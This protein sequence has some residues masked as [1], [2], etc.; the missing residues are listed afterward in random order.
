[1][2]KPLCYVNRTSDFFY[3]VSN[4]SY[5]QRTWY[6]LVELPRSC[7]HLFIIWSVGWVSSWPVLA[8]PQ[9]QLSALTRLSIAKCLMLIKALDVLHILLSFLAPG[10]PQCGKCSTACQHIAAVAI[11]SFLD[12]Y[13]FNKYLADGGLG[14]WKHVVFGLAAANC[15]LSICSNCHNRSKIA[16]IAFG[17]VELIGNQ[18]RKASYLH[19]AY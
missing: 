8:M 10:Q 15:K 12:Y 1:M 4:A 16:R 14:H 18:T 3:L 13:K 7:C 5:V 6:L 17:S 19:T 2:G 9:D 11:A